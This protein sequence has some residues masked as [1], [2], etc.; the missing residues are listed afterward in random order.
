MPLSVIPMKTFLLRPSKKAGFALI[1][2]VVLLSFLVLLLVSL[3]SLTK[4]ETQVASNSQDMAQARQNAFMGLTI[5]LGQ[6]QKYA[7]P[8]QRVTFP[9]TT[10]YPTKDVTKGTGSLYDDPT[11][12]YRTM[13]VTSKNRS[14]LAKVGTYLTTAERGNATS[15]GTTTWLGALN[16]Y[17][18]NGTSASTANATVTSR[19]PYWTGVMDSSLRVDRASN[20]AST[21]NATTR[22][23]YETISGNTTYGE[24]KR[25]QLPVWLVSGVEKYTIDQSAG[26]A[27]DATGSDQTATYLA[28]YSPNAILTDPSSS[29]S[30]SVWLVGNKSATLSSNSTDGLDGRVRV[31]KQAI[32]ANM[33]AIGLTNNT[34][35]GHYAYWVGDESTKANVAILNPYANAT[36]TAS[37]ALNYNGN[38][39]AP[40]HQGWDRITGFAAPSNTWYTAFGNTTT[41][42]LLTPNQMPVLNSLFADPTSSGTRGPVPRNFHSLTTYSKGLLTDTALGGLKRDLFYYLQNGTGL[43][44]TATIADPSRYSTTD[45]RFMAWGG[46]NTGFPNNS[47]YALDGIPTWGQLRTWYNN[48]STNNSPITPDAST[49]VGP[50]LT[51]LMFNGGWSYNNGTLRLHWMPCLVLWNPYDV[52]LA[53]PSGGYQVNVEIAPRL[54]DGLVCNPAPSITDLQTAAGSVGGKQVWQTATMTAADVTQG[55]YIAPDGNHLLQYKL[56]GPASSAAAAVCQPIDYVPVAG[57]TINIFQN[58]AGRYYAQIISAT[59]DSYA[60]FPSAVWVANGNLNAN[61]EATLGATD[62]FGR[63]YYRLNKFNPSDTAMSVS[64]FNPCLGPGNNTNTASTGPLGNINHV[65]TTLVPHHGNDNPVAY[66][67]IDR[68]MLFSISGSDAAFAAGQ[69]KVFAL[70]AKATPWIKGQP[71]T[72]TNGGYDPTLPH[73]M[74]FDVLT[75]VNGP[76]SAEAAGLKIIFNGNNANTS[77]STVGNTGNDFIKPRVTITINGD[78]IRPLFYSP[79]LG[80]AMWGEPTPGS[81]WRNARSTQYD[82]VAANWQWPFGYDPKVVQLWPKLFDFANFSLP[83]NVNVNLTSSNVKSNWGYFRVWNEPFTPTG[84]TN[85][86]LNLNTVTNAQAALSRFNFAARFKAAHPLVD[87]FRGG[88]PLNTFNEFNVGENLGVMGIGAQGSTFSVPKWDEGQA[89]G[90]DNGLITVISPYSPIPTYTGPTGTYAPLTSIPPRSARRAESELLSIGQLQHINLSPY[91]WEPAFPIGNSFAPPYTDRE[92]I[93][94]LNSRQIAMANYTGDPVT[95]KIANNA[96]GKGRVNRNT[97]AVPYAEQPSANPWGTVTYGSGNTMTTYALPGNTLLDLSYLLNENLWDHYF[98]SGISKTG[99]FTTY[100]PFATPTTSLTTNATSSV[101]LR[102]ARLK[103]NGTT[104]LPNP[105][106][107]DVRNFDSASAY[108]TYIGAFNINSTSVEA[109]KSLLASFRGFSLDGTST[110]TDQPYTPVAR[111]AVMAP[112]KGSIQFTSTTQTA[113]DI[114]ATGTTGKDYSKLLSGFRYLTDAMIQTLAERIVDE[115]RLRGPF[116]SLADF[117]NRRLVAPSGSGVNSSA[118]YSAR[119]S[120]GAATTSNSTFDSTSATANSMSASYDP[121]IGLQGLSGTLQRAIQVSGINGGV[122]DPRL[123]VTGTGTATSTDMAYTAKIQP[124]GTGTP[125]RRLDQQQRHQEYSGA[126]HTPLP[127]HRAYR[128]RSRR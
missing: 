109:W 17:W 45:S 105:T 124:G 43:S 72:L 27:K 78:T 117:V 38:L 47:T 121:F 81:A 48:K 25:D 120:G 108:L 100:N 104:T 51:Y 65:C 69:A 56:N 60:P 96:R 106:I 32:T 94:G 26:T 9:A 52:P 44:D 40:Q 28:N 31:E 35:I 76:P 55:F 54:T 37:N 77:S 116:M 23:Q 5:A 67:P 118:W 111:S 85:G 18:N 107:T 12:G 90:S 110:S 22:Q 11:Y 74:Y 70:P 79:G 15:T 62:A 89:D 73:D 53:A 16:N 101:A 19:N 83:G 14:Y 92:A 42:K 122:N 36:Y 93:A 58:T 34:T 127:R 119:I 21:A 46:S 61:K 30:T 24:F 6:L 95:G 33:T 115:V 3:A 82:G 64:Y 114:G 20:P 63:L 8:D 88:N 7:G 99:Q 91:Y 97:G 68:P 126:D 39:N 80:S 112:A 87:V 66:T 113:A 84:T 71:I 125:H 41:I 49:G 103:F 13:A 75:V 102:N 59:P 50:V 4:I 57:R 1:I 2:T 29:N 10:Y 98:L 128:R 86:S 123:G